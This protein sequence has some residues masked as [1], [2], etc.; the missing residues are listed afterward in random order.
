VRRQ[1]MPEITRRSTAQH[2]Q[3]RG[4]ETTRNS[5]NEK[6]THDFFVVIAPPS[7]SVRLNTHFGYT[8]RDA[9]ENRAQRP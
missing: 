9:F 2:T 5:A 1:R 7:P 4:C 6:M 8:D 3:D